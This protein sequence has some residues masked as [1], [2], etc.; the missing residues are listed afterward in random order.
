MEKEQVKKEEVAKVKKDK[1]TNKS[2]M[3]II[4]ILLLCII[5]L[6]AA[7]FIPSL[8]V[9]KEN[10]KSEQEEIVKEI[11]NIDVLT[12]LSVKI[13]TVLGLKETEYKQSIDGLGYNHG[14]QVL[15]NGLTDLVKQRVIL[16]NVEWSPMNQE[17]WQSAKNHSFIQRIIPGYT[18]SYI[19]GSTKY[20]SLDKAH[21]YSKQLFGEKLKT[22]INEIIE[23]PSYVY[24]EINKSF[25]FPEPQCGG[26]SV[27]KA[28][29]YKSKFEEYKD[30][31]YVYVSYAF[32]MPDESTHS[33]N[34][35]DQKYIIYKDFNL[36][37]NESYYTTQHKDIYQTDINQY[38]ADVFEL[39][40]DN[41]KD[42]S[43]Y[44]FIF[45]KDK[46]NN[47][48]LTKIEQTK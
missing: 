5:G 11:K 39:N 31:A 18:E 47:Y 32:I 29:G 25:Y 4:I 26:I 46:N 10:P 24:D 33:N 23:C 40:K 1:N 36:I 19:Y 30:E 9:K 14:H 22:I 27:E 2:L 3:V 44:K 6:L 43:E 38:Q 35:Y 13:D 20:V 15:K 17:I 37:Q 8:M 41:Y 45:K 16:R 34:M 48:Y 28:I 21:E 7:M 42:F 12:E